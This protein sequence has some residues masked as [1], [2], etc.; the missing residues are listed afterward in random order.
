M[1]YCVTICFLSVVITLSVEV[2][3]LAIAQHIL[4]KF[5][6]IDNVK[7]A[8]ILMRLRAQLGDERFSGTQV[9]DWSKSFKEG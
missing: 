6:I 9:Y 7:P 8:K 2:V 3:P 1:Y 4:V 5:L